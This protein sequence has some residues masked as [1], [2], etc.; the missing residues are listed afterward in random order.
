MRICSWFPYVDR[1]QMVSIVWLNSQK[2]C[3]AVN[4][5][6]VLARC[7]K[8]LTLIS[9]L[10][11]VSPSKRAHRNTNWVGFSFSVSSSSVGRRHPFAHLFKHVAQL[12]GSISCG[13]RK[14]PFDSP[15]FYI[16]PSIILRST[17]FCVV[18]CFFVWCYFCFT[19]CS[20]MEEPNYISWRIT[21]L[22]FP[23]HQAQAPHGVVPTGRMRGLVTDWY[24]WYS[25]YFFEKVE[26]YPKKGSTRLVFF[27]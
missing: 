11:R 20:F 3:D 9:C 12:S 8:S 15:G 17:W 22:K 18:Q 26:L 13:K 14:E 4:S 24:T 6:S 27:F 25:L 16:Q 10:V 2:M 7:L 5:A 23:S 19:I 21:P 1:F